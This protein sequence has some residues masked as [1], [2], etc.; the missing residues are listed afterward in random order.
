MVED[1]HANDPIGQ[2]GGCCLGHDLGHAVFHFDQ[3]RVGRRGEVPQGTELTGERRA[4]EAVHVRNQGH[5][6]V[7]VADDKG[8]DRA[9]IVPR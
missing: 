4:V 8:F 3:D 5:G 9:G 2:V 6:R 7:I 1:R